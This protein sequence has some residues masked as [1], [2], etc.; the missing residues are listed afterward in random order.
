MSK[1]GLHDYCIGIVVKDNEKNDYF[2]DVFPLEHLPNE[3]GLDT[4]DT[5]SIDNVAVG[6]EDGLS[7]SINRGTKIK[8]RWLNSGNQL[9]PPNC[10]KGES[11]RVYRFGD[12][13]DYFWEILQYE[14]DLRKK[15]RATIIWS[16]VDPKNQDEIVS[17]KNS[18]YFTVD[19]IEGFIHL[20]T[21]ANRKEPHSFDI[22]LD[23]K[24]NLLTIKDTNGS[25]IQLGKKKIFIESETI[26][27]NCKHL[28][29]TSED[30]KETFKTKEIKGDSLQ[31]NT[32]SIDLKG[33]SLKIANSL[34][35]NGSSNFT[36]AVKM[37]G[38][39]RTSVGPHGH[40]HVI[41]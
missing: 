22:H 1:S 23:L 14:V 36:S 25:T 4:T 29:T 37:N 10:Y 41:L 2:I 19:S 26:E 24:K 38:F 16:N 27:L 35:M 28:I 13:N 30:T 8:C 5:V 31:E 15:E 34:K 39:A 11:V 6:D 12:T 40:T 20:H 9:Y 3:D 17:K 18:H 32:K 21:A 7:G 33:S